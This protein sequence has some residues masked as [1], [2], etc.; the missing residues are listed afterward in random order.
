MA[1]TKRMR[2]LCRVALL[3]LGLAARQ[4]LGVVGDHTEVADDSNTE[5]ATPSVFD[6][7]GLLNQDASECGVVVFFHINKCAGGT[8]NEWMRQVSA[9]HVAD[10]FQ[11]NH[12]DFSKTMKP[13]EV[14]V[15]RRAMAEET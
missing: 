11:Q 8:I 5:R 14:Y 13:E 4:T 10:F 9:E 15:R 6:G 3:L 2:A 12:M 1:M 7:G